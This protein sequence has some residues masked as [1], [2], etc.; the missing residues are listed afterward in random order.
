MP[1]R[2]KSL[3]FFGM[4]AGIV[5]TREWCRCQLLRMIGSEGK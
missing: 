5:Q 1:E 3:V 4:F 2:R